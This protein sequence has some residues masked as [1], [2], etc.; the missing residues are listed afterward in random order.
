MS[1]ITAKG[2]TAKESAQK[3]NSGIDFK[4]VFIRL[5]DG[6]SVR[7]RVMTAED[8]IEYFA[9]SAYSKGIYTQP[10]IEPAG[11]DCALC[12]ASKCEDGEVD[13]KGNPVWKAVGRRRRYLFGFADID[14][15]EFRFFDAT[16]NQAQKIIDQIEEYA[17][18]IGEIAFTFKR[19]GVKKDTAYTLNPI[20]KLK[21]EDQDKFNVFAGQEIPIDLY[22]TVLQPRTFEKQLAELQK[23]GFPVLDV[24]GI[25]PTDAATDE[26]GEAGFKSNPIDFSEDDIPF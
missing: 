22:E 25:E 20:L 18:N 8:Y 12:I 1:I 17:E 7:V 14:T 21:K 6:E 3:D 4:K 26:S 2:K 11:M 10:C 13:E 24:F 19:V 16:K 15:G 9:H 5:K 23:A